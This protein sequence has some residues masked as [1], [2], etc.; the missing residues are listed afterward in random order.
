M[1]LL[2]EKWEVAVK[3]VVYIRLA[4]LNR[5]T[6]DCERQLFFGNKILKEGW[7]IKNYCVRE[8]VSTN[9]TFFLYRI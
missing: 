5:C 6:S 8:G 2:V 9:A 7:E 3:L 4:V 1:L